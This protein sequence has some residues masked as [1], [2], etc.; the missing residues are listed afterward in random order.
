MSLFV[1]DFL[2]RAFETFFAVTDPQDVGRW[3]IAVGTNR[4]SSLID[5][6]PRATFCVW[7]WT[8]RTPLPNT[9]RTSGNIAE[10]LLLQWPMGVIWQRACNNN[11][12]KLL[13]WRVD[14]NWV[15][16]VVV[17]CIGRVSLV[18]VRAVGLGGRCIYICTLIIHYR[19]RAIGVGGGI[20]LQ[21]NGIS[22]LCSTGASSM[23]RRRLRRTPMPPF[24]CVCPRKPTV[25]DIRHGAAYGRRAARRAR[26]VQG[27]PCP[28]DRDL[29]RRRSLDQTSRHRRI[30]QVSSGQVNSSQGRR[31]GEGRVRSL[32]LLAKNSDC[33]P[34]CHDLSRATKK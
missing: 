29:L 11:N 14:I 31:W 22:Y 9:S 30:L 15:V 27:T 32:R 17:L 8:T 26:S 16:V 34:T 4:Y 33:I 1:I 25:A 5:G 7:K 20:T 18:V 10:T 12:N 3:P 13:L 19:Q 23:H 28:F 21:G 2:V 6:Y 24:R